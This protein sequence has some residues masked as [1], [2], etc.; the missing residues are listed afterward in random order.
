VELAKIRLAGHDE[1]AKEVPRAILVEVLNGMV[2]LLHPFMPYITEELFQAL[3][4][5]TGEKAPSAVLAHLPLSD[6]GRTPA[7]ATTMEL[8][9]G[10]T[11]AIRT[12]RSQF[13]VPP[14]LQ[15]HAVVCAKDD[16]VLEA[17]EQHAGYVRHLARLKDLEFQADGDKPPHSATA[18]VSGLV[19]YVPLEGIIDLQKERS[20]LR[21][22][23]ETVGAQMRKLESKLARE[24]FVARAPQVEVERAQR[25]RKELEDK[26]REIEATLAQL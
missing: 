11:R 20:R 17:L 26:R 23:L 5:Y 4:P 22:E 13:N 3:K 18:L 15:I 6:G 8:V 9:M 7:T 25:R 19:I 14:G 2:K 16:S 12:I 24:E 10:V 1:A 21:K